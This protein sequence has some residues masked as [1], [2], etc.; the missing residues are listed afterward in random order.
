VPSV[1]RFVFGLPD[2]PWWIF[3]EET[4]TVNPPSEIFVTDWF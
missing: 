3:G 1:V 2:P 4:A